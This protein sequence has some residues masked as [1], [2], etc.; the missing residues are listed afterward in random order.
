MQEITAVLDD[1]SISYEK[2][3][4]YKIKTSSEDNH[5]PLKCTIQVFIMAPGLHMVDLRK[6]MGD[7]FQFYKFFGTLKGRLS[8]LVDVDESG[9]AEGD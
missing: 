9:R 6:G 7:I 2:F 3:N 1:L 8:H 4:G 5:S